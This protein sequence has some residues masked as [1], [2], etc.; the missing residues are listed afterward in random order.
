M[1]AS[2]LVALLSA[3]PGSAP[4]AA[5]AHAPAEADLL[6]AAYPDLDASTGRLGHGEGLLIERS[7]ACLPD[8]SCVLAVAAGDGRQASEGGGHAWSTFFA[9]RPVGGAW[10]ERASAAGPVISATGHWRIG[11]AVQADAD[12]ALV[13]VSTATSGGDEGDIAARHLW[14]WDGARFLLVLSAPTGK[15]GTTE[16]EATYARCAERPANR[17]SWELRTREREGRG[18][19]TETR[20]RVIWSGQAWV[21]RPSDRP[22]DDWNGGGQAVA[23]APAAPAPAPAAVRV[24]SASASTTAAV[25][26]GRAHTAAAA[27]D[28]DRQ[29]AWVAGG[30]RNGVGEWLQLDL[31]TP[32]AL[33]SLLLVGTCPG[34]DWKAGPRPK[35]IRL[36]FEDGP[37][38]E[39]TLADLQAPQTVAVTRRT[40][41]RWVRIELLELYRGARRQEACI[42]EVTPRGR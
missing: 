15:V 3:A 33:G 24:K 11:V 16:T 10:V 18:K 12:G 30:K 20:V 22:C 37:A 23:V 34:A 7:S 2:L 13:T 4:V 8:G 28:G 1:I 6:R 31:A 35:R 5:P 21:E 38:Q 26:R 27:I 9:F 19:W 29:T 41:A 40:P 14:S 42:T 32:T 25:P 39:E 36:R 17:P